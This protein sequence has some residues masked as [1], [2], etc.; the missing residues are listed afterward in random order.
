MRNRTP[1]VPSQPAFDG[2]VYIVLNYFGSRLGRAYCETGEDE[3]DESATIENIL[4]GQFSGWSR[5][6]SPKAGRVM[7]P[8]TLPVP[9][10][11]EPRRIVQS[12]K[13]PRS[14]WSVRLE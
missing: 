7:R 12:E 4:S 5:S 10:S 13:A 2:T 14:F 9:Y 8:R 1:L 6:T 3:A 11:T